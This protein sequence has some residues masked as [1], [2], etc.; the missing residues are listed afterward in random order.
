M[1]SLSFLEQAPS[2][3][4]QPVYVV[5]GDEDFLRRRV[6]DAL[7]QR[8]LGSDDNAA[9]GFSAYPGDKAVWTAILDELQTLPFLSQQRMVSIESADTFVTAHRPQLEKYVQS[10][11]RGGVLVLE[12]KSWPSNT[13]LYR[14][15]DGAASL[16]C[17]SLTG[18]KLAEWCRRWSSAQYS[19][20]LTT[21]AAQLLVDLVGPE[22]GL[23][24]Q[25]LA[26]LSV[27]VGDAAR[28]DTEDVD[29]LVG[30]N[31]AENTFQIF[32]LIGQGNA[33]GALALL[34]R[35]FGQGEKPIALLGAFSWQLRKLGQAARLAANGR[36][37]AEAISRAGLFK[38]RE[39]EQ[40]L[41]HLGRHRAY[42]LFDWLLS[43]DLGMKGECELPPET[44]LERLVVRLAVPN[45]ETAAKPR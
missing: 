24:D 28:I 30:N 11:P 36:P 21:A 12:V 4:P 44:Q 42:R 45:R 14:L 32:E 10:P 2:G 22:M 16:S 41:R 7:K 35:L 43:C 15:L 38:A 8:V 27:Y 17:K 34:D 37:M 29:R 26:K 6:L 39:A 3:A 25:E 19:K 1:D 20:Q 5:H 31:R 33:A 13:R 18:P 23:L 40:L 9:F